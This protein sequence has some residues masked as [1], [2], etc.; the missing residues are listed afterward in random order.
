MD[1][2]PMKLENVIFKNDPNYAANYGNPGVHGE[3][4]TSNAFQ[5][6]MKKLLTQILLWYFL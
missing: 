2:A 3:L 4:H 5:G 1:E 6:Y